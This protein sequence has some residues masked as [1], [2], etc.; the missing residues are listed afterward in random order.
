MSPIIAI[1]QHSETL[2]SDQHEISESTA[3]RVEKRIRLVA[4]HIATRWPS[5]KDDDL[6]RKLLT[7]LSV[8]YFIGAAALACVLLLKAFNP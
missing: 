5:G 6:L 4:K 7:L 8:I 3:T 1:P 2:V